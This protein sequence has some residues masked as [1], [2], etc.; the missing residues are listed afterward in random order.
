MHSSFDVRFA[1]LRQP[2]SDGNAI[3]RNRRGARAKLSTT[4]YVLDETATLLNFRK[5]GHPCHPFFQLID[6]S[7]A[8]SVIRVDADRFQRARAYFLKRIDHGYSFTDCSSFIC[9][10]EHRIKDALTHDKRFGQAGFNVLL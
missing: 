2:K 9:M 4:D 6:S 8:L 3:A 1:T 5:L 7:R 10:K